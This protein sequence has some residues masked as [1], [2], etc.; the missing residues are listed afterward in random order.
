MM[1][2]IYYSMTMMGQYMHPVF[3]C[4]KYKR[5]LR[6][7]ISLPHKLVML[8][9]CKRLQL[10]VKTEGTLIMEENRRHTCTCV[11]GRKERG[12]EREREIGLLMG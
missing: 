10:K 5:C 6:Q 4:A 2:S 1:S 3:F 9:Y 8:F 11:I 7:Q 12:G